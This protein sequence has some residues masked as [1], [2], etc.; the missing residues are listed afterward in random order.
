MSHF[1]IYSTS[2]ALICNVRLLMKE[3][4]SIKRI[5]DVPTSFVGENDIAGK[6]KSHFGKKK[7]IAGRKMYCAHNDPIHPENQFNNSALKSHLL[8]RPNPSRGGGGGVV[9]KVGT[10]SEL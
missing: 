2:F 5:A 4:Q 3:N 8:R 6:K 1:L 10:S 7:V 9:L